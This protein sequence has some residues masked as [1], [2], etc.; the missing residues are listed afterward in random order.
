ML[1]GGWSAMTVALS[2][3]FSAVDVQDQAFQRSD[4]DA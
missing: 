4:G 2:A 3:T 1:A